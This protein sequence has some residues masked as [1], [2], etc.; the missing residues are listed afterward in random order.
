MIPQSVLG[1][2]SNRELTFIDKKE[3][4]EFK[5]IEPLIV[6]ENLK[7]KML[8]SKTINKEKWM[9]GIRT[10]IE[11]VITGEKFERKN[12]NTSSINNLA[13]SAGYIIN[14]N[15]KAGA[16][17]GEESFPMLLRVKIHLFKKLIQ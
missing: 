10:I 2:T 8:Q 6:D 3:I 11:G 17:F 15:W 9:F 5:K 12:I 4:V 16:E 14:S 1:Y 13:L 7:D